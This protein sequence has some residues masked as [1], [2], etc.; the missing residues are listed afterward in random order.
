MYRHPDLMR[1]WWEI[2]QVAATLPDTTETWFTCCPQTLTKITFSAVLAVFP[3]RLSQTRWQS[4]VK[5][6]YR[7][8][9]SATINPGGLPLLAALDNC[10]D[11]HA[12]LP[13][14]RKQRHIEWRACAFVVRKVDGALAMIGAAYTH[15]EGIYSAFLQ[16]LLGLKE[17]DQL[18]P[19]AQSLLAGFLA[20]LP[21]GLD[22]DEVDEVRAAVSS[23]TESET[24]QLID[25]LLCLRHHMAQIC[26]SLSNP[27]RSANSRALCA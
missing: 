9:S 5:A 7:S 15:H 3:V 8:T 2:S 10:T 20:V 19:A 14:T 6:M 18:P 13:V 17:I 26:L 25:D 27:T 12:S 4:E 16:S 24:L 11:Q 21:P 1:F 23:L 22:S